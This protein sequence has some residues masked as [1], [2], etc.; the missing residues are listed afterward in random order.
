LNIVKSIVDSSC[1]D[2]LSIPYHYNRFYAILQPFEVNIRK[3][4]TKTY[5]KPIDNYRLV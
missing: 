2:L 5:Q 4:N 1:T 3:N